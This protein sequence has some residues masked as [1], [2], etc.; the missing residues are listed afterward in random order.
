[1][2]ALPDASTL[3]GL[4]DQIREL[5]LENVE[6]KCGYP[7]KPVDMSD[8]GVELGDLGIR[9]GDKLFVAPSSEQKVDK[10]VK[11]QRKEIK[12]STP[13][14]AMKEGY[15]T[16]RTIPDDNSCLFR[17]ISLPIFANL[18]EGSQLRSIVADAIR[19][20]QSYTSAILGK[21]RDEYIKWIQRPT[22]WGGSIELTILSKHLGECIMSLDV[23]SGRVDVYNEQS[24]NFIMVIYTGIH[25]DTVVYTPLDDL[26]DTSCD[27][28][29]FEQGSALGQE[30]IEAVKKLGL[31]LNHKG[32][33]TNTSTFAVRCIDCGAVIHGER[34]VTQH[35][36]K[37]GHYNFGEV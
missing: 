28:G 23:E 26:D 34:E 29:V 6:I 13:Y 14:T 33:V 21:D 32:Y 16:L 7:P 20:D 10:V 2:I 1:V 9:A 25:Y 22:A 37:T 27:I 15:C 11:E 3:Q 12:S 30:F 17:A 24:D 8:L 31:K 18:E 36:N 4:L 35:A 19:E 5:G